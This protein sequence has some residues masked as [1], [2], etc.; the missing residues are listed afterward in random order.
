MSWTSEVPNRRWGMRVGAIVL[1]LAVLASG[2]LLLRLL[3][4]ADGESWSPPRLTYVVQNGEVQGE[5]E[6]RAGAH[7]VSEPLNGQPGL[8]TSRTYALGSGTGFP[9]NGSMR[10][11]HF[12]ATPAE[13]TERYFVLGGSAAMG[14]APIARQ[15]RHTV[16]TERLPNGVRALPD[17]HAISGQLEAKLRQA[18]R[19]AEVINAG[20]IAQDSAGVLRIAR[21]VLAW[22]PTGLVL[23]LGN[24]E[25]IGLSA[26]MGQVSVPRLEPVA[27]RLHQLRLYR[28][29]ANQ[30][31]PARQ[32]LEQAPSDLVSG[33]QPEVLGRIT[34]AQWNA[35][36]RPLIHD[37]TPTDD[38]YKALLARFEHNIRA[39]VHAAR[40]VGATV[41]IVPTPPHLGYS[42]FFTAYGPHLAPDEIQVLTGHTRDGEVALK[43]GDPSRA[44]QA[45]RLALDIDPYSATAWYLLGRSLS[46]QGQNTEAVDALLHAHALDISR[47]RSQ[48]AFAEVAARVCEE[49]GCRSANAHARI[50]AEALEQGL[51]VY[52]DRFGDHE[53][54]H[55]EGNAW[56]AG[57]LAEQLLAEGPNGG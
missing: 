10:D 37:I 46:E 34:L 41:T 11:E 13:G 53:H 28:L 21:E 39:V 30:L 45:A 6:A 33:L 49:L 38:V 32:R 2:E 47:K 50:V 7:F 35:A 19:T 5:F 23:Y 9:V 18:G 42:P 15:S 56:I 57:L 26:G 40:D 27:S 48:P 29:L 51:S 12:T 25:G 4:V 1:G 52:E 8:R 16:Q 14:Q 31:I 36:G 44:S 22:K 55:P 54:L 3:G 24:N 20:M 17:A 43:R